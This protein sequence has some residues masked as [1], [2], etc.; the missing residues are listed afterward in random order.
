[1]GAKITGKKP[2]VKPRRKFQSVKIAVNVMAAMFEMDDACLCVIGTVADDGHENVPAIIDEK[3]G[4]YV[5]LLTGQT[6]TLDA[7]T[8]AF[9]AD[10][11]FV[12]CRDAFSFYVS[13]K[14]I[15]TV[16]RLDLEKIFGKE[17]VVNLKVKLR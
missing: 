11:W 13:D 3:S 12:P 6:S 7:T 17:V 10:V 2:P 16:K 5:N 8:F 1:M 14:S 9:S 4:K 15:A